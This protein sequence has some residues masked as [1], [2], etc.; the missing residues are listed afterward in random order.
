[1]FR[2]ALKSLLFVWVVLSLVACSA[3]QTAAPAEEQKPAEKPFRVAMVF[4][5]PINDQ[6]WNQAGYDG[7]TRI[8]KELGAEVAF[9]ENVPLT[10][11]EE[12]MRTF[13]NEGYDLVIGHGD[14]FSEA[15]KVVAA[16]LPQV[17]FAVVNGMYTADNLASIALF[18]E[19]VTYLAGIVAAKISQSGKIGYIGG[20]EIPPVVRN[21]VGL[22]MGAKSVNP[23][24]QVV[25]TYLG[26]F[27]DAAKG[28]EAALAM[29]E[30]GVDVIYYYVD[31]AMIG[32]HEAAAE[33]NIKL[34]GCIFDQ[35]ALAPELI[36]TSAVQDTATAIFLTAKD[37]K[38]GKFEGKQLLYG[39]DTGAIGLAPFYDMVPK[40][41][42]EAV[43]QAKE[44]IISGKIVVERTEG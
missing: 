9:R 25:T 13:A 39:L 21:G 43:K 37:A 2:K 28:K 23:D 24:I 30:Q 33:K 29:A 31:Q 38:E 11:V 6:S 10:D 5:G 44:D 3:Q 26:S 36:V 15:S 19:Q 35:H 34:I 7:L 17:N 20:L 4:P 8:E 14:Q 42:E 32:I 27:T 1:M 41:V 18:D 16:E 12:A 22:E 40:E